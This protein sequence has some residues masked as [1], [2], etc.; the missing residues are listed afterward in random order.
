[1]KFSD[2]FKSRTE[3]AK[4]AHLKNLVMLTAADGVVD[5]N[6]LAAIAVV[7][8]REG[9]SEDDFKRCLEN[10]SSVDFVMPQD[11]ETKLRYIKD[12]VLLMMSDGDIDEKELLLCKLVAEKLG[13]KHEITEAM[14][15][16]IAAEI[17]QHMDQNGNYNG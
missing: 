4:L 10:P 13:Y 8:T 12:M 3:R 6:E 7:M 17:K 14:I 5:K 11:K 2:L 16:G 1:M 9:L 15:L